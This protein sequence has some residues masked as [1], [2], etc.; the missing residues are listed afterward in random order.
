MHDLLFSEYKIGNTNIK[1]RFVSQAMEANDGDEGGRVSPR[2]I[3]RYRQLAKGQWGIVVVEALSV[4][5]SSLARVNQMILKREN[6]DG[7]KRLV[8]EFKSIAPD[9]KILFQVTH[10]GRKAYA[11]CSQPTALYDPAEGQKLLSET[12]IENIRKALVEGALL[13]EEAGAD[14]VDFKMCHGYFGCE[15]LRPGNARDDRW[16]GT[17]DNRTRFLRES[18]SEIKAALK[19]SDFIMGSR[20]SLYEGIRGGCG[21]AAPGEILEDLT[22]MKEVIRLMEKL[23]MSLC[24]C[25]SGNPRD[26]FRDHPA[27]TSLTLP[28]SASD[29]LCP[30]GKT[31]GGED[32]R[33]RLG[34]LHPQGGSPG[35]G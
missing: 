30:P 1:N 35:D 26:N 28:L 31:A 4:N 24:E 25:V 27:H 23:G 11:G 5:P 6:L 15:M 18:V 19:N 2:G 8:D 16:G 20:L 32:G 22:E 14:G 10:S 7:F 21:T 17:L 12:D 29:A 13:A 9:S 34:L 33:Y 3:E